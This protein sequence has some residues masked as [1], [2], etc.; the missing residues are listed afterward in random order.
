MSRRAKR[1]S[2]PYIELM[3]PRILM[4]VL[5]TATIGFYLGG[6]GIHHWP[7]FFW[8]LVG[9]AL[10][11]GGAGALNH[12]LERDIDS[13]MPRTRNR[14]L[15]SGKVRPQHALMM[16]TYMV[17]AGVMVLV[18]Q[19]NLM[20]GFLA[21]MTAFLYVL[22]YTPM[23]RLSWWNTPIGAIPG[24]LPPLGGWAAATG[25]QLDTGAWVLFAIMFVWQHPHFYAIAWM[26]REDYR[27][28][29]LK[30]LTVVD[31]SGRR[32]FR[33]TIS[34]AVL[35]IPLSL[36]PV[37]LGL[38]GPLYAVGMVLLGLAFVWPCARLMLTRTTA[39]A[40]SVLRMSVIYLP[41][42]LILFVID[43]NF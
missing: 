25:G 31:P 14:P 28:G 34:L 41:L 8:M 19:V 32:A 23:K 18:W 10:S 37:Y 24:A 11:S 40:R 35:L 2:N 21:L 36:V 13:L 39:D 5:I 9:V 7:T 27:E 38:S 15:P 26:F 20:T 42:W 43:F 1:P 4:M 30:M 29:G 33:Q 6:M 17:I 16:G 22:V 12:Y 3:K